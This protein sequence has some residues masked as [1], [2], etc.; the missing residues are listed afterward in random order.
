MGLLKKSK[1]TDCRE[2]RKGC[3]KVE[4]LFVIFLEMQRM[5]E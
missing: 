5:G 3:A 2:I 4:F 1:P